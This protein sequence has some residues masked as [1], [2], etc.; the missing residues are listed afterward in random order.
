MDLLQFFEYLSM[1][2]IIK[3]QAKLSVEEILFKSN[4]DRQE[5]AWQSS[6]QTTLR[7]HEARVERIVKLI[8]LIYLP[9]AL[10]GVYQEVYFPKITL[11]L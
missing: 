5:E 8:I 11:L 9:Q 2:I 4:A 1:H 10:L 3:F 6:N 7:Q